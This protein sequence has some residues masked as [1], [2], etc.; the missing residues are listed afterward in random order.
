MKINHVWSY[1]IIMHLSVFCIL[2]V[3]SSWMNLKLQMAVRHAI[4]ILAVHQRI[5]TCF[6]GP[7]GQYGWTSDTESLKSKGTKTQ[8]GR[9]VWHN[10]GKFRKHD[11]TCMCNAS[12]AWLTTI[13]TLVGWWW[14]PPIRATMQRNGTEYGK[15]RLTTEDSFTMSKQRAL[16][17]V[18]VFAVCGR[19]VAWPVAVKACLKILKRS[20]LFVSWDLRSIKKHREVYRRS[21][22]A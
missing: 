22:G 13:C 20:T 12:S 15:T 10:H 8:S 2:A 18:C 6:P 3:V 7:I 21:K 9:C 14:S 17:G 11:C 5:R 1:S 16:L 4:R 19:V